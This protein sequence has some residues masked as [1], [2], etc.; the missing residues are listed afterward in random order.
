MDSAERPS[1]TTTVSD[2]D[3]E[4]CLRVLRV[5]ATPEG[6][7]SAAFRAPRFK[8]LRQTLQL[9]LDDLR[10]QL[11]HGQGPDKYRLRKEKKREKTARQQ[12]DRAMDRAQAD[13]TRMRAERLR[14]LGELEHDAAAIDGDLAIGF[15]PDG[16]VDC[17]LGGRLLLGQIGE[18]AQIAGAAAAAEPAAGEVAGAAGAAGQAAE[19]AGELAAAAAGGLSHELHMLRACYTC[20]ARYR[21]LHPFYAQL[22]PECAALNYQKRTQLAPLEGRVV[23]VTGA[24]VKIGFQA[25]TVHVHC[26]CTAWTLH[27]RCMDAAYAR[28]AHACR[29]MHGRWP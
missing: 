1:S 4:A 23:L 13:K 7:V 14:M 27:G 21:V 8:P 3:L 28:A 18:I 12:Q 29:M 24:R 20:K 9:Y 25:R 26:M 19:A 22:C 10:G 2:E 5:L 16:A 11:F 15:V 17:D 6:G